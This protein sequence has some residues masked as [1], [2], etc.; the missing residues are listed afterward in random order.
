M[1]SHFPF[2]LKSAI[3]ASI[4]A[5][6]APVKAQ[7]EEMNSYA[8]LMGGEKN[9]VSGAGTEVV[10]RSPCALRM[11]L[12]LTAKGPS[13]EEA[14]KHLKERRQS[15]LAQLEAL[16][17]PKDSITVGNP[18]KADSSNAQRQRFEAMV[19]ERLKS[20]GVTSSKNKK[21]PEVVTVSANLTVQWPLEAKTPEEL[22]L[23]VHQLHKKIKAA[24]LGGAKEAAKLSPEEEEVMEEME[25]QMREMGDEQQNAGQ[26]TFVYVAKLTEEE[27]EKALATAFQRAKIQA[28]RTAKI[29]G[30]KL[31]PLVSLQIRE[32]GHA[33]LDDVSGSYGEYGMRR[34]LARLQMRQRLEN[35][36]QKELE[37]V[38]NDPDSLM[39]RFMVMAKFEH[40][41]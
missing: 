15:A 24:D 39:F 37:A 33:D 8:G 35:L 10:K 4:L 16:K 9:T 20:R 2:L 6:A 14:L 27:R 34:L 28:E 3:L 13:M 11:Y 41:K 40:A 21:I 22:L 5:S 1:Q 30:L 31:G 32:E 7:F 19:A 12:E 38:G 18:Q 26:P 17:A 25:I 23:M 29:A 36:D